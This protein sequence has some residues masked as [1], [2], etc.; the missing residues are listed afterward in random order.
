MNLN[1]FFRA[2]LLGLCLYLFPQQVRAQE[3]D[4]GLA[5][6]SRLTRT[7]RSTG[8]SLPQEKVYLH[9]DNTCYFLG[10][11]IWYKAYVVRSDRQ[12][13]TDLSKILYVELL[14]PDGYLVERQQVPLENDTTGYGNFALADS[15]YGGYCAPRR[16]GCSTGA[17]VR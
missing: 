4:E 7:V 16:V 12:V 13:P 14:T 11:T 1:A 9:L 5:A 8:S 17:G 15:L 2:F 3:P 6:I 10:D